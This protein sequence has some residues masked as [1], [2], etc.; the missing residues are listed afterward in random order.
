[1]RLSVF[2]TFL[3]LVCSAAVVAQQPTAA[4]RGQA[5]LETTAFIPPFWPLEA[6]G[7]AWKAWGLNT[8][9]ANYAEAFAERYGLHP[10]PYRNDGLPMGLRKT[11]TLLG[12]GL[13]IDCM[14]CHGGSINGQS[15]VGL[16]NSTLDIHALFEDLAASSGSLVK[17]PFQF[18][19]AR[20]T[21]EAGAFAVYLLGLRNPDLSLS[22]TPR[23]LGLHDTSCEDIPAWWLLKKKRTMYHVGATDAS[24]VRSL[25]QFMMHPLVTPQGF[26]KAEPTFHD[27]QQYLLNIE[28]PKYPYAVDAKLAKQGQEVFEM[29]CATCHGTY[30]EKWSY[31][32]RIIALEEIGT[33]RT[34]YDNIN[35]QFSEAYNASWFAQE[36]VTPWFLPQGQP[37]RKTK[38]Y[39]AP[40]LDGIWATAPYF[41]NGSVPTLEGVL[42]SQ[43]RPKRF[44][45][46]FNTTEADY[47]K[48]AVGWKITEVPYSDKRLSAFE[49]RKIYDTTLPGRGN[50]GHTYGDDLSPA[51]RRAVI[52]YLKTL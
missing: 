2:A 22:A 39:Q 38:G 5:A 46:S 21:N 52:E 33:D 30:G 24:S 18:S 34:R 36:P 40:P 23:D 29:N 42:N 28:A 41:H 35:E 26:T 7:Q 37:I 11:K 44:T 51:E 14:T 50:Q 12:Q 1:M 6:Y 9:P 25:M 43:A 20:G 49:K 17:P 19:Q 8:K 3:L 4:Q 27:I 47:D 15:I 31:P 16:G 48:V 32:N 13:A 45:R 10:A